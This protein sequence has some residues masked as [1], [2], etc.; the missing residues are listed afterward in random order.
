MSHPTVLPTTDSS[1]K[2]SS[3][4]AARRGGIPTLATFAAAGTSAA[5]TFATA[6]ALAAAAAV[7][8]S[9]ATTT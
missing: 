4:V 1:T 7:A 9:P 5:A 6:A 2:N 8:T 3:L